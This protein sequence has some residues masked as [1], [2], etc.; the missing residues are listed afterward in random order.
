MLQK[1]EL[2]SGTGGVRDTGGGKREGD[3]RDSQGG[4]NWEKFRTIS[5]YFCKIF[6]KEIAQIWKRRE[7]PSS[8]QFKEQLS[9]RLTDYFYSCFF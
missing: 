3:K 5:Q 2:L 1:P 4:G 8:N 6:A 7:P 9:A